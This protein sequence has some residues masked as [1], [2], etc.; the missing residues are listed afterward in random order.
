KASLAGGRLRVNAAVF[1][2]DYRDM[3]LDTPPSDAAL[4]TFPIVINAAEASLTGLDAE[5]ALALRTGSVLSIGAEWLDATFDEFVSADPNNPDVEPDRAGNRLPHAPRLSANAR[6][7]HA[8]TLA[9][10]EL[11]FGVEYR[12]QSTMSFSLY[13]DPVLVQ[14]AY[15]LLNA[16]L[17]YTGAS[18]RWDTEIYARNLTDELYAETILRRDPVSGTR[19]LWGAPR[20][21]GMRVGYRW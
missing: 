6:F 13:A 20:T 18:G 14:R 12:H 15:G 17:A 5:V 4:G 7:E 21:V 2:Y 9:G 19:R 11:A 16:S 3:Q 1:H 10:G 8:W